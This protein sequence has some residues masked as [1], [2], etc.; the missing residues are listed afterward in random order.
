MKKNVATI[1]TTTKKVNIPLIIFLNQLLDQH[2]PHL[3]LLIN[4]IS[5]YVIPPINTNS[6]ILLS[7]LGSRVLDNLSRILETF[8]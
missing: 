6:I 7:I 5:E 1:T 2:K 4:E 8:Y 3:K